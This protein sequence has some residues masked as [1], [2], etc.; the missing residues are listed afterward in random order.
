L[1]GGGGEGYENTKRIYAGGLSLG[2]GIKPKTGAKLGQTGSTR[3]MGNSIQ[4]RGGINTGMSS[5]NVL[6]R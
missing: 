4:E 6:R 2:G 1:G 5:P 3:H